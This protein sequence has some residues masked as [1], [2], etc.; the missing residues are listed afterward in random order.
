MKSKKKTKW[1]CGIAAVLFAAL[2]LTVSLMNFDRDIRQNAPDEN[3]TDGEEAGLADRSSDFLTPDFSELAAENENGESVFSVSLREVVDSYNNVYRQ[4]HRADYMN[5]VNPDNWYLYA[6]TSPCF[7]YDSVRYRFTADK[8]VWPLPTISFFVSDHDEIYEIRMTFDDHGYQE[9]LYELYKDLCICMEKTLMP[10]LSDT[11]T[12]TLFETLYAQSDLNF[13]GDHS[14]YRDPER[15]KLNAVYQQGNIGMYCIYGSGTIE[16][17]FVPLTSAA[18]SLLK[19][20]N[21]MIADF[22]EK[23]TYIGNQSE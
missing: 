15:P 3:G 8:T 13:F 2:L 20:E 7:G 1:S 12:V 9:R 18:A 5:P 16:I 4:T 21:V 23:S 17:C 6:E 10:G 14:L 19:S 11:E 22:K